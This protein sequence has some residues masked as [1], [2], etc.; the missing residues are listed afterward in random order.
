MLSGSTVTHIRALLLHLNVFASAYYKCLGAYV[1]GGTT[2][3]ESAVADVEHAFIAIK[4]WLLLAQTLLVNATQASL[5]AK[6]IWNELW[7]PLEVLVNRFKTDSV[8]EDFLVGIRPA[9][10][11]FVLTRRH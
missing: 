4:L 5:D 11:N 2:L 6:V 1:H 7:P 3:P 9:Q 10:N 8:P